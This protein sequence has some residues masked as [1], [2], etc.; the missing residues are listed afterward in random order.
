V[1]YCY[2]YEEVLRVIRLA[3]LSVITTEHIAFAIYVLYVQREKILPGQR[4]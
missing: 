1:Y 3:Y 4:K 2:Q